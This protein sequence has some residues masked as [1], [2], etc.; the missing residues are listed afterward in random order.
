MN[1]EITIKNILIC[2][3]H[4]FDIFM[5]YFNEVEIEKLLTLDIDVLH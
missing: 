1:F 3:E 5:N 4:D 2:E